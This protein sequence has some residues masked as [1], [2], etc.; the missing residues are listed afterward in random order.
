MAKRF[1][2]EITPDRFSVSQKMDTG[3]QKGKENLSKI[4]LSQ[5]CDKRHKVCL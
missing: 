3:K 5:K 2:T 4:G 1:V